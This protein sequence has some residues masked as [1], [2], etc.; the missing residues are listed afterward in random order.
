MIRIEDFRAANSAIKQTHDTMVGIMNDLSIS[1]GFVDEAEL[2]K[3]IVYFNGMIL[4]TFNQID[5]YHYSCAIVQTG[6]PKNEEEIRARA[7]IEGIV[8][9]SGVLIT[10]METEVNKLK[11]RI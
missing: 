10:K 3:I 5:N 8:K 6:L 11:A 9:S 4:P 1:K 2:S 7:T